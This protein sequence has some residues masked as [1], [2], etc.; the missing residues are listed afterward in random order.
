M[1]DNI[2]VFLRDYRRI[3]RALTTVNLSYPITINYDGGQ[4][5]VEA[6]ID[7]LNKIIEEK[8]EK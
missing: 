2:Q 7:E 5:A 6:R 1:G 8:N 3:L 4:D